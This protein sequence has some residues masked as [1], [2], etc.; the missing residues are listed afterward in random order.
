MYV[1]QYIESNYVIQYTDSNYA[2]SGI[3]LKK[4]KKLYVQFSYLVK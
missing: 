2:A 1:I 3:N 4:L